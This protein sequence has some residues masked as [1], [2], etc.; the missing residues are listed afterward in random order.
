MGFSAFKLVA[1]GADGKS[2]RNTHNQD[3]HPF[4]A[5]QVVRYIIGDGGGWTAASAS[6][7]IKAEATGIIEEVVSGSEFVVVYQGEINTA[8]FAN[9]YGVTGGGSDDDVWFLSAG[10]SAGRLENVAPT[11]GGNVIKPML[12]KQSGAVGLVTGYIG[13]VIGGKN[14]VSMDQLN[15]VGTILPYAGVATDIPTQWALCDG[16]PLLVSEFGDYYNRVAHRYGFYQTL[17]FSDDV[18][19]VDLT[20]YL[21]TGTIEFEQVWSGGTTVKG[22][23]LS[24]DNDTKKASV[25]IEYLDANEIPNGKSF[26]KDKSVVVTHTIPGNDPVLVGT[27]NNVTNATVSH[28]K[29]PD[30]QGRI[31]MGVGN[32]NPTNSD[33][34]L[35]QRGGLDELILTEAN[36]NSTDVQV[37][38][39]AGGGGVS[40]RVAQ[41]Q[42]GKIKW[43]GNGN[44]SGG[45]GSSS[46][47]G[48]PLAIP[49]SIYVHGEMGEELTAAGLVGKVTHLLI[50]IRYTTADHAHA[51]WYHYNSDGEE[52]VTMVHEDQ[53]VAQGTHH[54]IVPVGPDGKVWQAFSGSTNSYTRVLGY[55]YDKEQEPGTTTTISEG[56][57]GSEA[58]S[59]IQPFLASN[60]IIRTKSEAAVS[61]I[62]KIDIPDNGLSDH[63]TPTPQRGDILAYYHDGVAGSSGEYKNF[64]LFDGITA[65]GTDEDFV[66][67]NMETNRVGI[68]T[69]TPGAT[70][71]V[72][73]DV[74]VSEKITASGGITVGNFVTGN[75]M[76]MPTNKAGDVG[77]SQP[78][79]CHTTTSNRSSL[80][81]GDN[82]ATY[83]VHL[84]GTDR[85]GG[86]SRT[87]QHPIML[88][89]VFTVPANQYLRFKCDNIPYGKWAGVNSWKGIMISISTDTTATDGTWYYFDSLTSIGQDNCI[90][91]NQDGEKWND[92]GTFDDYPAPGDTDGG[93]VYD[94]NGTQTNVLTGYATRIG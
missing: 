51:Y 26:D 93:F 59:N 22:N 67:I 36:V 91:R 1:T 38:T 52:V 60:Y 9:G 17:S 24:W 44:E 23:V 21:T 84:I 13:T 39:G 3:N 92:I 81:G 65:D 43:A 82:G 37:G 19:I 12:I 14:T 5:G 57:G 68:G 94:T 4:K 31:P 78:L 40:S 49:D 48:Y 32:Y 69:V 58:F 16:R 61:I 76:P 79:I 33:Y 53:P 75:V 18:S 35:G 62:D 87:S 70:L 90:P 55:V 10:A 25:D 72:V 30:L 41:W 28:V 66:R 50:S 2:I 71:D 85:P 7:S 80:P 15:P 88:D 64:K 29:T 8:N 86:A 34:V 63:N 56:D 83:F 74:K 27:F 6:D 47:F 20:D 54:A 42:N 77:Y 11:E 73:G 45:G 46:Y 89:R